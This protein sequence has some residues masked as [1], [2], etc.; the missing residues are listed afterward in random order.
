MSWFTLESMILRHMGLEF[1]V[2]AL[3]TSVIDFFT[4][5]ASA[6]LCIKVHHYYSHNAQH[7]AVSVY[8]CE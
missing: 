7:L 2:I 4:Y 8:I 3:Q 5:L 1:L 6:G